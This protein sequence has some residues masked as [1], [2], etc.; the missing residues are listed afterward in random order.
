LEALF[1]QGKVLFSNETGDQLTLK[2]AKFEFL[3]KS[4]LLRKKS[5]TQ[6]EVMEDDEKQV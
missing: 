4:S 3:G 2:K 1:H 6:Q 5:H